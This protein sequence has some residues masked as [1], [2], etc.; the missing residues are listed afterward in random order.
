M[1]NRYV[2]SLYILET[3]HFVSGMKISQ[4]N[5]IISGHRLRS[6]TSVP[7]QFLLLKSIYLKND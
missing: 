6:Q 1:I 5:F 4:W 2:K 3:P 7:H